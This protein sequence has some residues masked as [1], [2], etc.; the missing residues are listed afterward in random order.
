MAPQRP[1]RRRRRPAAARAAENG[2]AAARIATIIGM[3]CRIR[4][5]GP[6]DRL[7]W[8]RMRSQ[9]WPDEIL[10]AYLAMIDE[11]LG[12][13]D[14]WSFIAEAAGAAAG[15]AELAIR[16]YANGCE[17]RPVP[18]LEG[19]WVE[20][21]LRRRRIGARLL[22]HIEAFVGRRGFR[23]IGS[24]AFA[25]DRVSHAAHAAW[26]FTETERVVYFRKP[27]AKSEP[28]SRGS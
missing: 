12:S 3:E 7:V 17:S 2:H 16:K 9:L 21:Q 13:D 20:E 24:D 19:I 10:D 6:A 4:E 1:K 22:N 14:A 15:F 26:G 18:F 8:A 23:E 28:R 11:I 5:M 25:D 27:L